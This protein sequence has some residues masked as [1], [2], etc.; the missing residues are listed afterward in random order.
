MNSYVS[1]GRVLTKKTIIA[2]SKFNRFPFVMKVLWFILKEVMDLYIKIYEGNVSKC[3]LNRKS[4][5]NLA[6]LGYSS[7]G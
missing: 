7:S 4:I 1:Y 5:T 2:L 6:V 3:Y